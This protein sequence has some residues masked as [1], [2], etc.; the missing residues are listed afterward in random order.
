[1]ARAG[2]SMEAGTKDQPLV[3]RRLEELFR[4]VHPKGRGPYSYAEVADAI[5]QAAGRNAISKQYLW[6][7]RTGKRA[8]ASGSYLK[9]LADFFGVPVGYFIEE[10]ADA[11]RVSK[12]DLLAAVPDDKVRDLALRAAGLSDRSLAA[13]AAMIDNARAIEGLPDNSHL[14][15]PADG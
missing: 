4:T 6:Q 8:R 2:D 9:L 15:D 5:N 14:F 7:L 11:T 3:A 12:R 10:D 1:M 13:L